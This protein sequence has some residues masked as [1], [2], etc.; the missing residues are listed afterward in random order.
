MRSGGRLKT[1]YDV[2]GTPEAGGSGFGA[3][4]ARL[5][6]AA[7][8]YGVETWDWSDRTLNMRNRELVIDDK[9]TPFIQGQE[10]TVF[11]CHM[12]VCS[13][14]QRHDLLRGLP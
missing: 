4:Y 13:V 7:R 3:G 11:H 10:S 6:D 9:I 12:I 2:P 8:R 1:L 5:H 14:I